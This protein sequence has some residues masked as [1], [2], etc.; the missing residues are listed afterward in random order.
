M[1]F[2]LVAQFYTYLGHVEI[3]NSFISFYWSNS[4][5]FKY[6][7]AKSVVSASQLRTGAQD[8]KIRLTSKKIEINYSF[9]IFQEYQS[10]ESK[11]VKK[12]FIQ[13]NFT[14]RIYLAKSSKG[15]VYLIG[16]LETNVEGEKI[17]QIRLWARGLLKGLRKLHSRYSMKYP[18]TLVFRGISFLSRNLLSVVCFQKY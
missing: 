10:P 15:I 3:F 4:F 18:E 11:L 5:G 17:Q 12:Q 16:S 2:L 1:Q 14:F 13:L 6:Y 8:K 7:P 9:I